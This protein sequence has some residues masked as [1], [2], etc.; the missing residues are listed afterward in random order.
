MKNLEEKMNELFQITSSAK[1]S[2]IKGELQ[3]KDLNEAVNFISTKFDEYEKETKEREQVI[4]N[5][6]ENVS[7][8]N[9][10]VENLEIEIDKYEQY[11]RRNCLLVHGIVETNDEVTDDLVIET[12][13]TK[14]NIEISLADLDLTHR[15]G[16]KKP[17][18]NEPRPIIVKLSRYNVRKKVF[19]TKK[20]L[21]GSDVSITESLTTKRMEILKKVRI[22]NWFTNV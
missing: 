15:I 2:Q 4:K 16:K 10:K 19:P 8:M 13:S 14:M 7:V 21:K 6:E 11:S 22:E 1:D 9:K 5:L 12:V 3:L 18:Q 17:G 20:N